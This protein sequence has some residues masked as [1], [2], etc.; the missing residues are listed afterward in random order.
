M[1]V[2]EFVDG[3]RVDLIC[4]IYWTERTYLT[5]SFGSKIIRDRIE[6]YFCNTLMNIN[7]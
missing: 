2:S 1:C 4:L 6:L 5:D 7:V 3:G